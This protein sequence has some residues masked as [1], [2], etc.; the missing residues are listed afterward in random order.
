MEDFLWRGPGLSRE[1][2]RGRGRKL[3]LRQDKGEGAEVTE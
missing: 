2:R 1:G 3:F